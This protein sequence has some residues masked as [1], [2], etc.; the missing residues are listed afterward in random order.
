MRLPLASLSMLF[1]YFPKRRAISSWNDNTDLGGSYYEHNRRGIK[2]KFWYKSLESWFGKSTKCDKFCF[3]LQVRQLL[4]GYNTHHFFTNTVVP[5]F[6]ST[7]CPSPWKG[8]LNPGSA[9]NPG[10]IYHIFVAVSTLSSNSSE[11]K[12]YRPITHIPFWTPTICECCKVFIFLFL[13]SALS[14]VP[15]YQGHPCIEKWIKMTVS[16][17]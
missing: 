6:S 16:T 15:K 10:N 13:H 17:I 12:R 7:L 3:R 2:T 9:L 8:A 4:T 14:Y 5:G 1:L 11:A